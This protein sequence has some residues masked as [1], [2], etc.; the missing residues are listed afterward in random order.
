MDQWLVRT[1][2]N[3][4]TGPHSREEL[5]TMIQDVKLGLQDEICP[6]NGYWF[7]LH[8]R[9]EVL[10]QLGIEIPRSM[11][12]DD[13]E[14]ITETQTEAEAEVRAAEEALGDADGPTQTVVL[15]PKA[16]ASSAPEAVTHAAPPPFRPL[17]R[18]N[19]WR[20]FAWILIA[21]IV[22]VVYLVL[23]TTSA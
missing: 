7:F 20:G 5:C 12:H 8:E 16:S 6:G 2:H 18:A 23:K 3:V 19:V 13:E 9:Q 15:K 11:L 4:I 10:R 1:S 22:F 21:A 14:D 17:E